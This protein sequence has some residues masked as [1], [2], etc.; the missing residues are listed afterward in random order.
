M[1]RREAQLL[2]VLAIGACSSQAIHASAAAPAA[3]CTEVSAPAARN[4]AGSGDYAC[5][6][7]I[8]SRLTIDEPDNVD[9][10]FGLA[11]VLYWSGDDTAALRHLRIARTMAPDY[12]DV[13]K[14]EARVRQRLGPDIAPDDRVEFEQSARRRFGEVAWLGD[15][16]APRPWQIGWTI[17]ASRSRLN[18]D[19]PDWQQEQFSAQLA[20]RSGLTVSVVGLRS[21]RF[22]AADW[23]S[24]AAI[25]Y[26]FNDR[27]FAQA[28]FLASG[29]ANHL[30]ESEPWLEV[31]GK[32]GTGWI[33]YAR[34]M[35]TTG[36]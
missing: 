36:S 18:T 8:Y 25:G 28:G 16:E 31:A 30:P 12:E 11:Q 24:G 15:V 5:A 32:F 17:A 35:P 26:A 13:W 7:Q 9:Y 22:D 2:V 33:A 27:W 1:R 14:L 10:V 21:A 29:S 20:L 4:A 6:R 23:Q 3:S 19:A 34:M